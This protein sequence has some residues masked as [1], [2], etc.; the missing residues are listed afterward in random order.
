M[1]QIKTEVNTLDAQQ[2]MDLIYLETPEIVLTVRGYLP[3]FPQRE[4]SLSIDC[5][6]VIQ[7]R[8]AGQSVGKNDFVP[9]L[10]FRNQPYEII[11]Q[12]LNGAKTTILLNGCA[13]ENTVSAV[14][15]SGLLSGVIRLDRIG[16]NKLSVLLAGET[17]L[18][19]EME[20]FPERVC[21]QEDY[22]ALTAD[23]A[24]E[25]CTLALAVLEKSD[26]SADD[27]EQT[28]RQAVSES[29]PLEQLDDL[30]GFWCALKFS[31]LFLTKYRLKSQNVISL[32]SGGVKLGMAD[33]VYLTFENPENA[34]TVT[35]TSQTAASGPILRATMQEKGSTFA[36]LPRYAGEK[37]A[38]FKL[39]HQLR[40]EIAAQIRASWENDDLCG[41][42]LLFPGEEGGEE[43]GTIGTIPFLPAQTEAVEELLIGRLLPAPGIVLDEPG[44]PW[45]I[46]KQLAQTD[47]GKR[48]VLAGCFRDKDQFET[49]L[50][51]CFYYTPYDLLQEAG[52][53]VRTVALMQTRRF[54][55]ENAG[56]EYYGTVTKISLVPRKAIR[57][58][59][60]R[61]PNQA[62]NR[63]YRY[64]VRAWK[65]LRRPIVMH[66][67]G[68]LYTLTTK[69]LLKNVQELSELQLQSEEEYRLYQE[70]KRRIN[71]PGINV[72][73]APAGFQVGEWKILLIDGWI[74]AIHGEEE[75]KE[76]RMEAF[77]RK[78]YSSFRELMGTGET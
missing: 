36:F 37:N 6:Q 16:R 1:K 22:E 65:R 52:K 31:G 3:E 27:M 29:Y 21:Y 41:A 55:K 8:A 49:C 44:L 51:S 26:A 15:Q 77:M 2:F 68:F 33:T 72:C 25:L 9:P 24:G 57:E 23:A 45:I 54:F 42:Y 63:Y 34:E 28:F 50:A 5:E 47:W 18:A 40:N 73:D 11:A 69:F 64:T 19:L 62:E 58:V 10:L 61:N 59:P 43:L 20:V 48:D 39:L 46:E 13:A 66:E 17:K 12:S 60:M 14:G 67:D 35:L 30:Y 71:A 75:P 56:V 78:P 70:L 38:D 74:Q 76:C 53:A 32:T 7:F 4:S